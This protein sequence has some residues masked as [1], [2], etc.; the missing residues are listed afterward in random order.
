MAK[1]HIISIRATVPGMDD[2]I[3]AFI[4]KVIRTALESE[5]VAFPC[6]ISVLLTSDNGIREINREQR[7]NRRFELSYVRPLPRRTA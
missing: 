1:R 6:E 3:R 7:A 2:G 4:R 5:G